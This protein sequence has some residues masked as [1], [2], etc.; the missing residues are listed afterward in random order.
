MRFL[1]P[2]GRRLNGGSPSATRI[3]GW[4]FPLELWGARPDVTIWAPDELSQSR[5]VRR[6]RWPDGTMHVPLQ[7]R[8][9]LNFDTTY[10]RVRPPGPRPHPHRPAPKISTRRTKGDGTTSY[11]YSFLNGFPSFFQF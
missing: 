9:R 5:R 4:K 7:E 10:L 6:V 3:T 11:E 2:G 1:R 8:R